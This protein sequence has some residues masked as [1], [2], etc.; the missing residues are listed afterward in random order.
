MK[1]ERITEQDRALFNQEMGDVIPLNTEQKVLIKS[2]QQQI[3]SDYRRQTAE[4]AKEDAW[5]PLSMVLRKQL[6]ADDWLSF[7]RDGIQYGVFKNLRLGKY[8]LEATLNLQQQIPAQARD[9]LVRFID[10]CEYNNLR[11]LL[12]VFGRGRNGCLLKSYL[13]QWLVDLEKVQVFHSALKHHGGSAA[14]YV[15]LRKSEAK[16]QQNRERHAA[17]LGQNL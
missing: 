6:Q 10:D 9:E 12:I 7:K 3:N 15:L 8:P 16:R 11:S 13:N 2:P 17:R 14:V 1:N 4:K 5:A